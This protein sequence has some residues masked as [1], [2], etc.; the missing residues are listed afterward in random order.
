MSDPKTPRRVSHSLR[1]D[2]TTLLREHGNNFL[3]FCCDNREINSKILHSHN[4]SLAEVHILGWMTLHCF[5]GAFWVG[6]SAIRQ[7]TYIL[8]PVFFHA[9]LKSV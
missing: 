2:F 7:S 5:A 9:M 6:T 3:I 1:P 4:K 8:G